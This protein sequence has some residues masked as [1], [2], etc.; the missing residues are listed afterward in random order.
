MPLKLVAIAL[1][2]LLVLPLLRNGHCVIC[3]WMSL[4]LHRISYLLPLPH[5]HTHTADIEWEQVYKR[6]N[7]ITISFSGSAMQIADVFPLSP[8]HCHSY[9][10]STTMLEIISGEFVCECVCLCVKYFL[11][12]FAEKLKQNRKKREEEKIP[13]HRRTDDERDD[14][15]AACNDN[16]KMP[17]AQK[18][19]RSFGGLFCAT[20]S[21][22]ILLEN[23]IE[24]VRRQ[25]ARKRQSQTLLLLFHVTHDRF[26]L[27]FDV[28]SH[29]QFSTGVRTGI[30]PLEKRL[31]RAVRLLLL[32][33]ICLCVCVCVC[34]CPMSSENRNPCELNFL[35]II[36]FFGSQIECFDWVHF[37]RFCFLQFW[38]RL[39]CSGVCVCVSVQQ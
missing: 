2:L 34:V 17:L 5:S 39:L 8:I 7:T 20:A 9:A 14:E 16:R 6:V 22:T 26:R 24:I 28:F 27:W 15:E 11:L 37:E 21:A 13:N 36:D 19:Q 29:V 18:H 35:V 31:E 23:L 12:G 3:V 1:L 30:F 33:I 32:F 4:L 38:R 10:H 25:R